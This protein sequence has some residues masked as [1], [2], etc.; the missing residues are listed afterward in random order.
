MRTPKIWLAEHLLH[1]GWAVLGQECDCGCNR[2]NWFARLVGG[3]QWS[4]DAE[5]LNLRTRIKCGIGE[6]LILAHNNLMK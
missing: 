2:F 6:A 1:I 5:P 4:E 3:G